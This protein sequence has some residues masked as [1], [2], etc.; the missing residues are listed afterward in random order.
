LF[1]IFSLCTDKGRFVYE[2]DPEFFGYY[3]SLE[4]IQYWIVFRIIQSANY[5]DIEYQSYSLDE[6]REL[7]E[8]A[9]RKQKKDMEK[10]KQ[11]R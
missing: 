3:L 4:E 9:K 5:Y 6:T 7:I 11:K 10:W 1:S 2:V 8:Q